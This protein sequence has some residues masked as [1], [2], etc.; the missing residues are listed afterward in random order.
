MVRKTILLLLF[1]AAFIPIGSAQ[2]VNWL[3]QPKYDSIS[4]FNGSVFKCKMGKQV[5]LVNAKGRELLVP[6]ADSVTN[7]C[8]NHALILDKEGDMFKIRGI[9]DESGIV[10]RV[11]GDYYTNNYS[12]FSEG[13]VSVVGQSHKAGYLDVNGNLLIPCQYR[14]A[15][16]FIQGWASVEPAKRKQQTL[17]IDSKGN[18][19]KIRGFH[20]G[21]VIMGSSF[22]S[23]GEA[24]V[25]Y[26]DND[27]VVINTQG[28]VIREYVKTENVI[29]V[30]TY[31]FSF[32]ESGKNGIPK[33]FVEVAYDPE[34]IP[35]LSGQLFGYKTAERIVTLPQFSK[36]GKFA[37]GSAIVCHKG[38]YGIVKLLDGSFS[39]EFVGDDLIVAVGKQA[40]NYTYN[41]VIPESIKPESLQ[42]MFDAGDGNMRTVTLTNGNYEFT[43]VI[44]SADICQMRIEVWAEGLLLWADSLEK[45]VTNVNLDVSLPEAISER[46]NE[47][48]E[49]RI[50]SVITNNSDSQLIVTGAFSAKFAEGSNNKFGNKKSFWIKIAPNSQREVYAD[51]IVEEEETVKVYVSVKVNQESYGTKSAVIQLKPFY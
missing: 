13:F 19:L 34:P 20:D 40:P 11:V 35:F 38:K 1:C 41:L 5:Q 36:A 26:Y 7:Y 27:N 33:F 3:V 15:R 16:P 23:S 24:L 46:A 49:L 6:A 51:L 50:R 12:F 47:Q 43:P 14:I 17:Y 18:T 44:G 31:D 2:T 8:E 28:E 48:D 42:I 39:G 30:R 45:S 22:N 10:T 4:Y 25:A 9:I 21:K 37:G 32:D 29:P